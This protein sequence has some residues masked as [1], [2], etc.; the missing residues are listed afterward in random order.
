MCISLCTIVVRS[1]AQSSKPHTTHLAVV[2]VITM[3]R[4]IQISGTWFITHLC[5]ARWLDIVNAF[6]QI[7]HLCGFSPLID[8]LKLL[9]PTEHK[10]GYFGDILQ[11]NLLAWYGETIP[12]TTKAY[13]RQSKQINYNTK[14]ETVNIA[15]LLQNRQH[16]QNPNAV[17]TREKG[18]EGRRVM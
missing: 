9:H 11:A 4:V 1:T 16:A 6:V 2:W 18:K 3:S 14:L 15:Q 10:K 17:N 12:N 7:P 5:L 8:W 13:I